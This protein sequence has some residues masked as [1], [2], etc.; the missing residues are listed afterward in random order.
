MLLR[1]LITV[2]NYI[3]TFIYL[4][5]KERQ[6]YYHGIGKTLLLSYGGFSEK[7]EEAKRVV[8]VEPYEDKYLKKYA[9]LTG[10]YDKETLTK[11]FIIEMTP[12]GNVIMHY[13]FLKE[14]FVYYSDNNIP[15]R[16]LETVARK[17]VCTFFCKELLGRS[18]F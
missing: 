10:S 5:F 15:F 7:E 11:S 14:T 3:I 16:Y 13:D 1:Y 18:E 6:Q 17:Y 2:S 9:E 8:K 4:A 12:L